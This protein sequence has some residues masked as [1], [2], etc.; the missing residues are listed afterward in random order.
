MLDKCVRLGATLLGLTASIVVVRRVVFGTAERIYGPVVTD[1]FEQSLIQFDANQ[2]LVLPDAEVMR[3][4]L[5]DV[6]QALALPRGHGTPI[7]PSSYPIL[8]A[9]PPVGRSE[10]PLIPGRHPIFFNSGRALICPVGIV[11]GFR[12]GMDGLF[13][14]FLTVDVEVFDHGC[15]ISCVLLVIEQP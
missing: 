9:L 7:L 13:S 3:A 12:L 2:H 10:P 15:G 11:F 14:G 8:L 6:D 4:A 5:V 1:A